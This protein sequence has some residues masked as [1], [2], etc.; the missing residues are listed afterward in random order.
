MS[1]VKKICGFFKRNNSPIGYAREL[2]VQ[3]GRDCKLVAITGGTFGSEPYLVKLGDHVEISYE[4]SFITHDGGVWVGREE[5]PDLDVIA[6]IEVGNNV[7]IGARSILLPGVKIG[8]NCVIGAGSVVRGEIP[9]G[10]VAAGVPAKVVK[11]TEEYILQSRSRGLDTKRLGPREK[12]AFL[13]QHF[14]L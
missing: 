14:N 1:M 12:K 9:S 2:G 3:I 7:F 11:S 5:Y 4:V 10:T 13:I 8:D 6:P